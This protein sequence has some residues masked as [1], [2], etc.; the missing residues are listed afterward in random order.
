MVLWIITALSAVLTVAGNLSCGTFTGYDWL[1]WLP[2]GFAGAFVALLLLYFCALC[3]ACAF[4]DLNKP[5]KKD[6]RFYRG[7][8]NLTAEAVMKLLPVRMHTA[9]LE[10][11]PKT[12][13]FLLVCNHLSQLDPV[14]LLYYFRESKL[15]FVTKRENMSMLIVGK[16]MHKTMCQPIN[17]ENDREA[18]KTILRCV[19]LVGK[20]RV[21]MAVFPEGYTS[22]DHLLHGF[23]HGVFKIAQKT[24]VPIVV[25]TVQNTR[26]VAR[27]A[28]KLKSTDVHLHLVDVIL[29]EDYQGMTT[30]ELGEKVHAMMAADLGPDLVADA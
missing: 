13:P 15:S 9:G 29:P 23:R 1:L 11:V 21:P 5:Q 18:L 30:V 16:L 25:C 2:L 26:K 3:L 22:K 17:R 27:N 19:E 7:L 8:L 6:S 4:V 12:G 20:D 28:L 10:K 14:L 24:K